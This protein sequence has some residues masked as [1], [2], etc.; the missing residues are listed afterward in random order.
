MMMKL[1]KYKSIADIT[2]FSMLLIFF[3]CSVVSIFS[4]LLFMSLSKDAEIINLSGSLR[5]Q[6]YRLAFEIAENE[7]ENKLRYI[8]KYDNVLYSTALKSV[9]NWHSTSEI[10]NDYFQIVRQWESIKEKLTSNSDEE[11]LIIIPVF[12]D[13]IDSF[14]KEI[15]IHS[16]N[17]LNYLI[18]ASVISATLI[19]LVVAY[20][21]YYINRKVVTPIIHLSEASQSIRQGNFDI[22]I[23]NIT[24][25]EIGT[26]ST[27]FYR[28]ADKIRKVYQGLEKSITEQNL[29]LRS[30]QQEL[31][32]LSKASS[33]LLDYHSKKESLEKIIRLLCQADSVTAVRLEWGSE[34]I[35]VGEFKDTTTLSTP[36]N[37]INTPVGKLSYQGE[38][39]SIMMEKMAPLLA[40]YI[41]L[42]DGD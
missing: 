28:M 15:Q 4:A 35:E 17:K 36:L 1:K 26:L 38:S 41:Q 13:L 18:S 23:S 39:N 30:T 16:E 10:K 5:M 9:T 40:K 24:N 14:V 33:I 22:D 29:Q 21:I 31:N 42:S 11:V 32:I 6:S 27:T 34:S 37:F 20:F 3:L 12:V 2:S 19:G 7:S 8:E 25:N